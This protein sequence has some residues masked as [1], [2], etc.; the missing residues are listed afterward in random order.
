M[1]T[2]ASVFLSHSYKDKPLVEAVARE[3]GQRGI[4]VWLD[5]DELYPGLTL[6]KALT[7]AIK[8][9]TAVAVFLSPESVKAPW[10]DDEVEIAFN[11]EETSGGRKVVIPVC[12]GDS[13]DLV[14]SQ[15]R[16][17]NR[18]LLPTGD[19]I[20]RIC[21]VPDKSADKET[22]AHDIAGQLL[23]SIF[24]QLKIKAY[25]DVLIYVDQRGNGQ[26]RGE[27]EIPANVK[28]DLNVVG[29]VFRPDR[30]MRS[31]GETLF[32]EAWDETCQAMKAG[33]AEALGTP[34]WFDSKRLYI[35]G[36]AQTGFF[37]ILGRHFN[38][39][40]SARLYCTNPGQETLSNESQPIGAP[41]LAGGNPHCE[42]SHHDI[43]P[44]V[45]GSTHEVVSLLL[46]PEKYIAPVQQF[47]AAEHDCSPLKW[48]KSCWF[49]DS[50]QAIAYIADVVALLSRLRAEHSVR[51]VRLFNALPVS[52]VPLLAANL[53]NEVDNIVFME[54]RR[55]LQE[56]NPPASD[57]YVPLRYYPG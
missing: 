55:D 29:L 27:P 33:L 3:L 57:T 36:N 25:R 46:A 42:T 47:R 13:L 8:R 38:R 32:G 34:R 56:K 22:M 44:M 37:Y 1:I 40:T 2:Y 23:R 28:N 54:Y 43:A 45:P 39:N 14:K 6:T 17:R 11:V 18:L 35:L 12:L 7:E 51:T 20:N 15:A 52:V 41:Q 53:L 48:V 30:G 5:K 4:L 26:R 24:D 21:V 16:L 49:S 10:L 9:Q 19:R 31:Q 50:A